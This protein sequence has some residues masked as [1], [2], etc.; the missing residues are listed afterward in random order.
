MK[1]LRF[2][3]VEAPIPLARGGTEAEA[4]LDRPPRIR[5]FFPPKVFDGG[6][7]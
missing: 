5:A 4:R 6:Q 2:I 7:M 1:P 3:Q